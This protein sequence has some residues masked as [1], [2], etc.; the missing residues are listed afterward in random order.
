MQRVDRSS[1]TQTRDA[2]LTQTNWCRRPSTP[3]RRARGRVPRRE[4]S[5]RPFE[6]R[7]SICIRHAKD[8]RALCRPCWHGPATKVFLVTR[9]WSGEQRA[10]Y[11]MIVRLRPG[12]RRPE[13]DVT[14][15]FRNPTPSESASSR[16]GSP[17]ASSTCTLRPMSRQP[18]QEGEAASAPGRRP[19]TTACCTCVAHTFPEERRR[20]RHRRLP[21]PPLLGATDGSADGRLAA[22]ARLSQ[23]LRR[24]LTCMRREPS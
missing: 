13:A 6:P 21:A 23:L 1:A 15:R 4:T 5:C 3:W 24:L 17:W 22:S 20:R 16:C 12:S 8:G 18:G 19:A 2:Y 10:E 7:P 14:H 11:A 9:C